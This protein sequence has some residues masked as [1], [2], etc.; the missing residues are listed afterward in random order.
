MLVLE[1]SSVKYAGAVICLCLLALF[2]MWLPWVENTPQ[3]LNGEPYV[4]A[5]GLAGIRSGFDSSMDLLLVIGLAPAI[6]GG[7]F[8]QRWKWLRDALVLVSGVLVCWWIGGL[9]YE[10][11]STSHYLIRPGI[12]VVLVSG[13]LLC[14]LSLGAFSNRLVSRARVEQPTDT[15][16]SDGG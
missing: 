8:L 2:G 4:T 12:V 16:P 3:Y 13:I 14:L 15:T 11:W 5:I 9:L 1:R 6:V 7:L 10:Y